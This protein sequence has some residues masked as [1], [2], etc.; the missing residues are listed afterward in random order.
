MLLP[1]KFVI[2]RNAATKDPLLL[3]LIHS[4]KGFVIRARLQRLL[5]NCP[6]SLSM[7]GIESP[8]AR[9][10]GRHRIA[11]VARLGSTECQNISSPLQ[12]AKEAISAVSSSFV[13]ACSAGR[14]E[15][16]A[17]QPRGGA[18]FVSPALQRR[19][20]ARTLHAA[21]V[22][23]E[24]RRSPAHPRTPVTAITDPNPESVKIERPIRSG[25]KAC[26]SAQKDRSGLTI[27]LTVLIFRVFHRMNI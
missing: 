1:L 10:S 27:K 21:A 15:D 13:T 3:P 19:H 26:L 2:L 5:R 17:Q 25:S 23:R 22:P 16:N 11:P 18:E 8:S 20:G 12:R 9:L 4:A 24:S 6:S 14:R 7:Q